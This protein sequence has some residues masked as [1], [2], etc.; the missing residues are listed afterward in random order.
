MR[1]KL[2][3]V[4]GVFNISGRGIAISGEIEPN[5]PSYKAGAIV[6]LVTPNGN[7]LPAEISGLEHIKPLDIENFTWKKVGV[8][9]KGVTEKKQ[10][11]IGTEVFLE[12]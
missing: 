6:V 3:T 12:T 7:E 10:I 9:L 2:F 4:D 8:M 5:S 1:R 11:P